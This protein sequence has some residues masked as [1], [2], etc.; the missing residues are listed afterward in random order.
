[1]GQFNCTYQ[2]TYEGKGI[3]KECIRQD[4]RE[5][6]EDIITNKEER[7]EGRKVGRR[8]LG[9]WTLLHTG[10]LNMKVLT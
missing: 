8:E 4:G 3:P 5:K 1:V 2:C 10:Y 6:E 7:K 9:W